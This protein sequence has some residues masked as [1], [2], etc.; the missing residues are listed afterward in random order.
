MLLLVFFGGQLLALDFAG[1]VISY[2]GWRS[3]GSMESLLDRNQLLLEMSQQKSKTYFFSSIKATHDGKN[4]QSDF[5]LKETY[6]DYLADSWDVRIGRQIIAWGK[7]DGLRITDII[8]PQDFTLGLSQELEDSRLA[9]DALKFSYYPD[10]FDL[11][12]IYQPSIT[13]ADYPQSQSLW[14]VLGYQDVQ[15]NLPENNLTSGQVAA[16]LGKNFGAVDLSLSGYYFWLPVQ[17]FS[18]QGTLVIDYKR[19]NFVGLDASAAWGAFVYRLESAYYQR[20][21]FAAGQ[22][23]KP[24]LDGLLGVDWYPGGNW[25]VTAQLAAD[26]ICHY[27]AAVQRD[28]SQSLAT[29]SIKKK[30]WREQLEFS[31]QAINSLACHDVVGKFAADYDCSQ[32]L[33]ILVG[34]DYYDGCKQGDFG[35]FADNSMAW[36]KAKY[37]F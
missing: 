14:N 19:D 21:F 23:Q 36:C 7:A 1:K 16:K 4:S 33:H 5:G 22:E 13:Q 26:L 34:Y 9:V 32:G 27:S 2:H 29:L 6:F 35:K 8:C 12:L 17:T 20:K 3:K 10:F 37:S 31:A 18:S 28:E 11:E 24:W 15:H 25:T 30:V